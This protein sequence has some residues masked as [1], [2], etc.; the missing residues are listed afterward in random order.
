VYDTKLHKVFRVH[1]RM[2]IQLN[3]TTAQVEGYLEAWQGIFG[4]ETCGAAM[5]NDGE[6]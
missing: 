4:R 6:A 3:A 5:S 1:Y 2:H